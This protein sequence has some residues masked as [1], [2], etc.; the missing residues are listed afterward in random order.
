MPN[1]FR[2]YGEETRQG[3]IEQEIG[4]MHVAYVRVNVAIT[5]VNIVKSLVTIRD[6]IRNYSEALR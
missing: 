1:H 2:N 6:I 5:R 4:Q 3:S